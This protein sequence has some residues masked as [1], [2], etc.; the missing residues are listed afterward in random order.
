MRRR[1]GVRRLTGDH[2]VGDRRERVD[3]AARVDRAIAGGLLGAH[4]VR[5]AEAEARLCDPRSTGVRNG[6]RDPEVGDHGLP[7][8]EQDVLR[9]Q[10]A[11]NHPVPMRVVEC[12]GD[13]DRETHGLVDG[14]MLLAI[15]AR[16]QRL[17][18][19]EWHHIKQQPVG[20]A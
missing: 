8:V 1:A 4:V 15:E 16:A 18:L 13:S 14:E 3:I 11:M 17:A 7:V 9:L 12:P 6:E 20:R 10:V 5:R 19:D 2:L